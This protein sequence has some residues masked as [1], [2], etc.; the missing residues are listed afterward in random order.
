MKKL[1]ELDI[2]FKRLM[3]NDDLLALKGGNLNPG[4]LVCQRSWIWGGNCEI[5]PANCD[6]SYI[7]CAFQCPGWETAVCA[8]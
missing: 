2:N 8:G 5:Y 1:S 7:T 6:N 4:Y 3:N